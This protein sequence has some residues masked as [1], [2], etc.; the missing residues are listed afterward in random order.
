MAQEALSLRTW[1]EETYRGIRGFE[2][3]REKYRAS[4][5][6]SRWVHCGMDLTDEGDQMEGDGERREGEDVKFIFKYL[7]ILI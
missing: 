5:L 3:Q 7:N 2:A 4:H 1:R 6:G